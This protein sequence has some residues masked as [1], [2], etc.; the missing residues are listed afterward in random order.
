MTAT[1]PLQILKAS[2][3]SGKTFSLTL[4]Y[5][6][7]LL[8]D[9]YRYREI[10]AV[11]FTN[12]AT[13]E[14][15]ER[16]LSVLEGLA[17][18][19]QSKKINDFSTLLLAQNPDWT[20]EILQEK[21]QR[22]YRR[23]LHDYS[24]FTVST[25]DG[26][27]Q[28][29]IRSF[30]YEL[31]LDAAYK[32]EMNT[33]KVKSDLTMMLNQLLDERPD[34]LDWIIEYAKKKIANNENWNYRQQ[35]LSFSGLIFSE[36]FQEFDGHLHSADAN[37]VF[38]LLNQEVSQMTN[39]F[40]E[41]LRDA[42][43]TFNDTFK[44]SGVIADEMKDKSRNKLISAAKTSP[45]IG[46]LSSSDIKKILD[47]YID[48]LDNENAFTDQN[49]DVRQDL[50]QQFQPI[51]ASMAELGKIFPTFVGYQAVQSNLYFL[52]LLKEMSDLLS[53]WRKENG[54]QLISDSQLL[55]N[56]LGLDS[57][58]DPT[59]IWEKIG[60]RYN[61]FLFD[62]FQDTS[63]IQWKNFS[64]LLINALGHAQG[65]Q[66][67]HLIVGD[68]KQSIY[69]WR[70]GDW[71]ILLQQV[72]EQIVAAFNLSTEERKKNF[73]QNDTLDTNYRSLPHIIRFNN[74][75]Y[76]EI[77]RKLQQVLNDHVENMLDEED[78]SWWRTSGNDSLLLKAYEKSHQDIPRH[79]LENGKPLG[80][81]DILYL[82]VEDGRYR[83][84]QVM[85]EAIESLCKQVGKWLSSGKYCAGQIGILV[86]KNKEARQVI[87]ALMAYKQEAGLH[88]EVISG[89]ALTL[90][91]NDAVNLLIE[92]LKAIVYSSEKHNVYKANMAYLYHVVQYHQAFDQANWLKFSANNMDE[93]NGLL[94]DELIRGW[95]HWQ[96]LPL[97]QL[98]EKL[99]E[100]YGLTTDNNPHIPYLLTFKDVVAGFASQGERGIIQFLEYW[101]EDGS[102]AVLPSGSS[103]QLDAIEVTTVH[104]SKG[105][106]YDVVMLPF[107]GWDLDGL[108]LGNFWID[109]KGT[110]FEILGKIPLKYNSTLSHSIFYK[111]YL[112]EMLFN[113]M[114]ALN[115]LYVATTRTVQHLYI[116]APYFKEDVDKKTGTLAT[117]HKN[118]YISDLLY[119]VLD[120]EDA[121]FPISDKEL[122]ITDPYFVAEPT[123]TTENSQSITIQRY[124]ISKELDQALG[125]SSRRNLSTILSVEPLAQY[126]IIAHE[127]LSEV[128][129]ESDIDRL[130]DHYIED[131]ILSKENRAE[132]ME[133]IH[134]VW[135]HPQISQW[136]NGYY[137]IWNES[138]II[139]AD[140]ETIRPDKVFT[141]PEETIVLD[142]KF[143]QQ[144]Y[145]AHKT[146][147][148]KYIKALE[149][150][151]Y[152]NV[153]GYLYYAKSNVLEEVRR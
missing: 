90:S 138:S 30:T 39:T 4:H 29:V 116:T 74:Y 152:K 96:R 132:L 141:S 87:D 18:G 108:H 44:K 120:V 93:L 128:T 57:N 52:R 62:E 79:K 133:Q 82:P 20:K 25:I 107:A 147:V 83:R 1:P 140:G 101:A 66:H 24:R 51:L 50:M 80:E 11:T 117:A 88:F 106:A 13:A 15:K 19:N 32:I 67:E 26:F 105:L 95:P 56:K 127:I 144:D 142:F 54:A 98:I 47:K 126:G 131:G 122:H 143:T 45:H 69:R 139:T 40:L 130:V 46:K 123:S 23:I 111:Q 38:Q 71:R 78:Q 75:I 124:P 12:K 16:I 109:T 10:L 72:E 42:I 148:N 91:A 92:T 99:I 53:Q 61:Y 68:V 65:K 64:P 33:S 63:R 35:L 129:T 84:N 48:L 58:N 31:N 134:Q 21:A 137:K 103:G 2:A 3:G 14:M 97:V 49:K 37:E 73:I 113:Y 145:I 6:G 76:S 27:S 118:E 104:K 8:S 151:G 7:L 9:E 22:V 136:L 81:I 115:A 28:K 89:D 121:P 43:A 5:I 85:D 55:L 150:L 59:F 70:N 34:L 17:T 146:Q 125:K 36:N 60:N 41:T 114:D 77:P 149:N 112:E 94:P 110:P 119:Q 86:R 153:K 135:H 102:K 100:I